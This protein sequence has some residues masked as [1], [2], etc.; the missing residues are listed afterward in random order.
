MPNLKLLLSM[1]YAFKNSPKLTA[2]YKERLEMDR[3]LQFYHCRLHTE[4]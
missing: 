2:T 1:K 3:L 4:L